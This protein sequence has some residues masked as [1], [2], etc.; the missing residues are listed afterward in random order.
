ML[1]KSTSPTVTYYTWI[2]PMNYLMT[3]LPR[4]LKVTPPHPFSLSILFNPSSWELHDGVRCP[5]IPLMVSYTD[6]HVHW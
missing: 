2:L 1:S 4:S 3:K 5:T 6:G